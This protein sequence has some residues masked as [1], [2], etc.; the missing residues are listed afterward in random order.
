MHES[1]CYSELSFFPVTYSEWRSQL[2]SI[3]HF[4]NLLTI[5]LNQEYHHCFALY[6][7]PVFPCHIFLSDTATEIGKWIWKML[8]FLNEGQD[9]LPFRV[10]N[11]DSATRK[12]FPEVYQGCGSGWIV[13][14]VID[15]LCHSKMTSHHGLYFI[16]LILSA[17]KAKRYVFSDCEM[18]TYF[19]STTFIYFWA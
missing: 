19:P 12:T 11:R 5:S 6:N 16:Q 7:F 8:D 17:Q 10:S 3:N 18:W 13:S 4:M 9:H 14:R 1:I 2:W 15:R